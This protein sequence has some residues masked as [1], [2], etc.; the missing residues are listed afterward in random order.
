ME[1]SEEIALFGCGKM[2][3]AYAPVLAALGVCSQAVGRSSEGAKAFTDET[4]IPVAPGG[5]SAWLDAAK[6][7]PDF[8]IVAVPVPEL[9]AC[10]AALLAKGCRKILLEKPGGLDAGEIHHLA[11]VAESCGADVRIAYN[12]RFYAATLAAREMIRTDGGALSF[13]FEFTE[14]PDRVTAHITEPATLRNWYL[15]NSSHVVDL[16][17]YMG[18]APETLEGQVA[19]GLEWHP[20]GSRFVG[21]GRSDGGALFTYQA[22]WDCPGS[23][24]LEVATRKRKLIFR[25]IERLTVQKRGSFR[26]EPVEVDYR[27]DEQFKP[28]VYRQVDAFLSQGKDLAVLPTIQQHAARLDQLLGPS[29]GHL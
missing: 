20:A 7:A 1:S 3:R 11:S 26:A 27:L 17:F 9:A 2:G 22:N 15:A 24:A 4:A 5:W 18:G 19:G 13:H 28:G 14:M 10:T 16:A 12:R 21:H 25:P 8:A 29:R 6:T 23:F